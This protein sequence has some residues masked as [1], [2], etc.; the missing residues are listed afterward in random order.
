MSTIKLQSPFNPQPEP[1]VKFWTAKSK[2]MKDFKEFFEITCMN[3][4]GPASVAVIGDVGS[5]KTRLFL[6]LEEK[7][8][9]NTTKIV[10]YVNLHDVFNEFKS[11]YFKDID[12]R[13]LE[14]FYNKIFQQLD[15]TYRGILEDES[16]P[17]ELKQ[18]AEKMTSLVNENKRKVIEPRLKHLA[19]LK[20]MIGEKKGELDRAVSKEAKG[21]LKEDLEMLQT[22]EEKLLREESFTPQEFHDFIEILLEKANL[23]LGVDVFTLYVDELERVTEIERDYNLPLKSTVESDLRDHFL[24]EFGPKGFKIIVACTRK[25]WVNFTERFHS[26]FPPKEIPSLE[27]EDLQEAIKEHLKRVHQEKYD[28]FTDSNAVNLIA[29]YS[30]RNFRTCM[31][32]LRYCYDEYVRYFEKGETDWKCTLKYVIENHFDKLI[33]VQLYNESVRMLEKQFS[34][35]YKRSQI[36]RWVNRILVRF[37]EFENEELWK[38]FKLEFDTR[39]EFDLFADS[40]LDIGVISEIREKVYIVMRENLAVEEPQ[41]DAIDEK[42]LRIFLELAAG[43]REIEKAVYFK[44]LRSEGF[45]GVTIQGRLKGLSDV[46]QPTQDKILMI[47]TSPGA[48]DTIKSIIRSIDRS[49]KAEN[50]TKQFAPYVITEVWG[51]EATKYQKQDNTWLV[52]FWYEPAT[53]GAINRKISGFVLFR[54]YRY[55]KYPEDALKDDIRSVSRALSK[56]KNLQFG[57]VISEYNPPLPTMFLGLRGIREEEMGKIGATP[58]LWKRP[59]GVSGTVLGTEDRVMREGYDLTH[60]PQQIR[61]SNQIF[62]LPIYGDSVFPEGSKFENE[63]IVDFV[64]ARERILSVFSKSDVEEKFLKPALTDIKNI[65]TNPT[66]DKLFKDLLDVLWETDLPIK[67]IPD[68]LAW[69]Q[70]FEKKRWAEN[71]NT[72]KILDGIASEGS[73]R[74]DV[75]TLQIVKSLVNTDLFGYRGGKEIEEIFLKQ[76]TTLNGKVVPKQFTEIFEAVQDKPLDAVDIFT[77]LLL[78]HS[79]FKSETPDENLLTF[80]SEKLRTTERARSLIASVD[81]ALY[82]MS[83][84]FPKHIVQT[85]RPEDDRFVYS[86]LK[87]RID[88]E[89][90]VKNIQ[91]VQE[92]VSF[93]SEK[94]F[95]LQVEKDEL[96]ELQRI[97]KKVEGC[98]KK[99]LEAE[100]VSILVEESESKIEGKK[101]STLSRCNDLYSRIHEELRK[102]RDAFAA[103]EL[104]V[105]WLENPYCERNEGGSIQKEYLRALPLE[106]K[107]QLLKTTDAWLK[108]EDFSKEERNSI[109]GKLETDVYPKLESTLSEEAAKITSRIEETKAQMQMVPNISSISE[110]LAQ[111]TTL[112]L[113]E[114]SKILKPVKDLRRVSLAL[115]VSRAMIEGGEGISEFG[116]KDVASY[117]EK[118]VQAGLKL[119]TMTKEEIED[120]QYILSE[121]SKI[122]ELKPYINECLKAL[123]KA[124]VSFS[125]DYGSLLY[126]VTNTEEIKNRIDAVL[127]DLTVH[128]QYGLLILKVL[129]SDAKK[130]ITE[131]LKTTLAKIKREELFK[132]LDGIEEFCAEYKVK[133]DRDFWGKKKEEN[134]RRYDIFI[135][136]YV[137]SIWQKQET[138]ILDGSEIKDIT[139]FRQ[140]LDHFNEEVAEEIIKTIPGRLNEPYSEI[141]VQIKDAHGRKEIFQTILLLMS[142]RSIRKSLEPEQI[143]EF[144]KKVEQFGLLW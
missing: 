57:L 37:E 92:V 88:P 10:C 138:T 85:K 21:K 126:A 81:A 40:L 34:P 71:A 27:R 124:R 142:K 95:K 120:L 102:V 52:S 20:R 70:R 63:K 2:P 87:T 64:L 75:N 48:L 144:L 98:L 140:F 109:R 73:A 39:H 131:T 9:L 143:L 29:Y 45:D 123:Q 31:T 33:R 116:K 89:S 127:Q 107:Q 94:G 23:E 58:V 132:K 90:F 96:L 134:Q 12:V 67:T 111:A 121:L 38:D 115:T 119:A 112:G 93:L 22:S 6:Y 100:A 99:S 62:V 15:A 80:D 49:T 30:Y 129:G 103:Y 128:Q 54:D 139:S 118:V 66:Y 47:G 53:A 117:N 46:L 97:S 43:Q 56:S 51:W 4:T 84:M 36:E 1:D 113:E 69:P 110:K 141:L 135:E 5:G 65:I 28:P 14:V 130:K 59:F 41:R 55:S 35:K 74:T 77:A 72:L 79:A 104:I 61:L 125:Q 18:F 86:L 24:A 3:R 50:E 108:S 82:V 42:F 122:D 78:R 8:K 91:E 68:K 32:V 101:Q 19:T 137:E 106:M 16:S 76:D 7:F 13:F 83:K 105:D 114:Y 17:Q 133:F 136:S 11:R 44:Q 60:E 25:A 26:S